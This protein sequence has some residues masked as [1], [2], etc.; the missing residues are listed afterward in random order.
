MQTI[1]LNHILILFLSFVLHGV[2]LIGIPGN[3]HTPSSKGGG[4]VIQVELVRASGETGLK[5]SDRGADRAA[6]QAGEPGLAKVPVDN[7]VLASKRVVLALKVSGPSTSEPETQRLPASLPDEADRNVAAPSHR[8]AP[9]GMIAT[10]AAQ[11]YPYGVENP[12]RADTRSTLLHLLRKAIDDNKYYPRAAR[13]F[14]REGVTRVGFEILPEGAVRQ[15]SIEASSG[16]SP[17]DQAAVNAVASIEPFTPAVQHL[18]K[19]E[20]FEIDIEFQMGY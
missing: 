19:A 6:R 2:V 20:R 8:S 17:L 7:A 10:N 16:F 4:P 18:S 14:G 3:T 9:L 13:R 1:Q 11:S 12:H 15:V 5:S